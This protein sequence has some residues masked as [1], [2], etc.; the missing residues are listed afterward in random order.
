M[1]L[2]NGIAP[3]LTK[4][5]MFWTS[6]CLVSSGQ[7]VLLNVLDWVSILPTWSDS[8]DNYDTADPTKYILSPLARS[9]ILYMFH[10]LL[11]YHEKLCQE[12]DNTKPN[13]WMKKINLVHKSNRFSEPCA[14]HFYVSG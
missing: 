11:L 7:V 14:V 4:V 2:L 9:L 5:E 6:K 12:I 13:E 8:Q 10:T 1:T 3:I